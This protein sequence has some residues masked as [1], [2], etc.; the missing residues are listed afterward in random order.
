M[1]RRTMNKKKKLF[2][3]FSVFFILAGIILLIYPFISE[4]IFEHR[5]DS[6]VAVNEAEADMKSSEEK[7]KIL[8]ESIAYNEALAEKMVVITDPFSGGFRDESS[9]YM[10]LLNMDGKGYMC[11]I[12]IPSIKVNLP[13]RHGTGRETL[14]NGI[15]H[16]EGSSLPVGGEDTHCVLS[17]HTGINHAKMFT[18]LSE[19]KKGDMFYLKVMGYTLAYKVC[20][21]NIVTPEDISLL[22]I[23]KGRDLCTLMTCTPYGVNSHR[24][25][26]TGERT[27]YLPDNGVQIEKEESVPYHSAWLSEYKRALYAGM[28]AAVLLWAVLSLRYRDGR[29]S[30]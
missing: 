11:A 13:V 24:L 12:E 28:A 9:D 27:E 4:R 20:D 29:R 8:K 14:E 23:R 16:L 7:E 25:L 1:M 22:T 10:E 19:M 2:I 21:I 5:A 26:V 30:G 15:G 6:I 17:G 3:C 18:D